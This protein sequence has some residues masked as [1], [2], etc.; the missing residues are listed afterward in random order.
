MCGICGYINFNDHR[1]K[2]RNLDTLN[3]LVSYLSNRGP[4][5]KQTI[6]INNKIFL[7]HTRL[8][9]QNFLDSGSQ[10]ITSSC[11]NYTLLFNGEIYD[12][13]DSNLYE[14]YKKSDTDFLI[15]NIEKFGFE[16]II[17]ELRGMYAIALFD[18]KKNIIYI[19]RDTK[20]MKPLYFINQT[21]DYFCFSSTIESLLFLPNF[22]KKIDVFSHYQFLRLGSL[23]DG[24]TTYKDIKE[25]K[26]GYYLKIDLTK[27]LFDYVKIHN[28][29]LKKM[30]IQ[31]SLDESIKIHTR[32]NKKM[33]IFLSSG[34]DSSY[35]LNSLDKQK[36]KKNQFLAIT[37]GFEKF[38]NTKF[39]EV[40]KA[41]KIANY[42]N[43]EHKYKIYSNEETKNEYENFLANMNNP[44]IDGFNT[45]LISSYCK[46]IGIKVAMSG[47]GADELFYGYRNRFYLIFL[48]F[49]L[50]FGKK[51]SPHR[52]RII[53]SKK[54]GVN[55]HA[56]DLNFTKDLSIVTYFLIR[57][58]GFYNDL[59]TCFSE[60]SIR[61]YDNKIINLFK[62]KINYKDAIDTKINLIESNFYLPNQIIR[63]SDWASMANSLE[64]R[65]PFVDQVLTNTFYK[66]K[67]DIRKK[68][69]KF[70]LPNNEKIQSWYPK[71][72]ELGFFT[73]LTGAKLNSHKDMIN[74]N[75]ERAKTISKK[76][77]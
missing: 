65:M 38:L 48:N 16:K 34:M 11:G 70:L 54:K 1:S 5:D 73:P 42:F 20:G 23:I 52:L 74:T 4:D 53:L 35:I 24:F 29:E 43:F 61:E 60:E 63:D 30:T 32:S 21:N 55:L 50:N 68:R 25:L 44:T 41:E 10:P 36:F 26:R 56:Y 15:E 2:E 14:N 57:G 64:I 37:I 76:F 9:I 6:A 7:G 69:K 75:F 8:S 77:F 66:Y 67:N 62:K 19:A 49:L 46:T 12:I 28:L 47:V 39:D 45:W 18:K 13:S 71:K 58:V 17:H 22:K 51:I 72:K 59:I 27:R 3:T 40:P 31:E 33:G